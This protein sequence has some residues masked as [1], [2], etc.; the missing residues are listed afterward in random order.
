MSCLHSLHAAQC[1]AVPNNTM[2]YSY[3]FYSG[4]EIWLEGVKPLPEGS[5]RGIHRYYSCNC[6]FLGRLVLCELRP[7]ITQR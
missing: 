1:R 2:M 7:V 6:V 3:R 4:G 5:Y